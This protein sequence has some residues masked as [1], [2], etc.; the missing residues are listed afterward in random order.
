M[1]KLKLNQIT[2]YLPYVKCALRGM[3]DG[4]HKNK[5]Y[6]IYGV[7]RTSITVKRNGLIIEGWFF[8]DVFPILKP[9]SGIK[10]D[11]IFWDEFYIEFGGGFISIEQFKKSWGIEI[12]L[13]PLALGYRHFKKLLQHRYDVFD[14]ISSGL[15]IDANTL[16]EDVYK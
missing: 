14:L 16:D 2:P 15:A 4:N 6:E 8:E 9:L 11:K 3:I 5:V 10:N 7:N 1:E 12:F 13:D